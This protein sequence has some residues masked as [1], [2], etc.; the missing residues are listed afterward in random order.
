[1]LARLTIEYLQLHCRWCDI[2]RVLKVMFL[3]A[4]ITSTT[5]QLPLLDNSENVVKIIK[6]LNAKDINTA[7]RIM[8]NTK[9]ITEPDSH[10]SFDI[11]VNLVQEHKPGELISLT[12][13]PT[14]SDADSQKILV[15]LRFL[16]GAIDVLS[17]NPMRC[18]VNEIL[19]VLQSL[20]Q[21]LASNSYG[22]C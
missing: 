15:F 4:N 18:F 22:E 8:R 7:F 3:A 13:V 20:I 9:W 11:Q 10:K 6:C 12:K 1:M 16:I 2:Y 5:C 17:T 14:V 21:A 19:A